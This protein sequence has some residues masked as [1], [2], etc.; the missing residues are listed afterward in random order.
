MHTLEERAHLRVL[1]VDDNHD[2]AD[3][4]GLLLQIVG[5]EV[6]VCYDG[7]TALQIAESFQPCVCLLDL[8]MPG[9]DGDEL[10][11]RLRELSKSRPM[12]LVALTARGDDAS[13]TRIESAGFD[14]HLLKPVNPHQLVEVVD[15]LWATCYCS[16]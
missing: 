16:L 2:L 14:M 3:S 9:M 12:V 7:A 13:C 8:N 4:E 5:F 11:T 6:R 10:A 1:C 15:R